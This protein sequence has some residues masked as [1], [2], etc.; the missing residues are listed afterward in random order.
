M[1]QTKHERKQIQ[2]RQT[3]ANLIR[4]NSNIERNNP[5]TRFRLDVETE[6]KWKVGVRFWRMKSDVESHKFHTEAMRKSGLAILHG[7]VVD[8]VRGVIV[9]DI[10]ASKSKGAAPDKIEDGVKA[11]AP[12]RGADCG[13]V[14]L[15]EMAFVAD[16]KKG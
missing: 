12:L 5:S 3:R 7:R 15:D 10:P 13:A 9:A 1:S 2:K 16:E 8:T 14:M 6:G 11:N 4:R